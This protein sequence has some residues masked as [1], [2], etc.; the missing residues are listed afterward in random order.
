MRSLHGGLIAIGLL[1]AACGGGGGDGEPLISGSMT[2]SYAGDSFAPDAGFATIYMD[3]P[4]IGVGDGNVNCDS[5]NRS[6]P[7]SGLFA[8][9]SVPFTVGDYTDVF[10]QIY[11]NRGDFNSIGSSGGT[12]SITA[13]SDTS[14]A[15]TITWSF[16]DPSDQAMYSLS[17]TFEVVNCQ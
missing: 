4:L 13:V 16:T 10:V 3:T 15:G 17:G 8:G 5:P 14:I 12:A 1:A 11:D 2:G 9:F 6:D 7:P